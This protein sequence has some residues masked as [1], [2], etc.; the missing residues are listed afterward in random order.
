MTKKEKDQRAQ[1]SLE[2]LQKVLKPGDTVYTNLQHVSNSGM[3]RRIRVYIPIV[4]DVTNKLRI[5]DISW[6]VSN[7]LGYRFND[8]HYA[9]VVGGCGMD[10]GYHVVYSLTHA[11]KMNRYEREDGKDADENTNC[12]GLSHSWI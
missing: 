10:M 12:Y 9:L 6:H 5:W 7:V 8:R 11:L 1:E 3:S 4:D 2:F